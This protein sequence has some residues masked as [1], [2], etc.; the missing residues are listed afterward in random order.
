MKDLAEKMNY[1]PMN[2]LVE[3]IKP[4]ATA[5]N[6]PTPQ[7]LQ[8]LQSDDLLSKNLVYGDTDGLGTIGHHGL[9]AAHMILSDPAQNVHRCA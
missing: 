8:R 5:K 2:L 6:T 3:R 7:M 1:L 9:N 4:S